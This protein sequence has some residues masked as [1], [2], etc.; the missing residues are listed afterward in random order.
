MTKHS[1]S[2]MERISKRT[3][4]N[5]IKK[6]WRRLTLIGLAILASL[7]TEPTLA[8]VSSR[9]SE[10]NMK[11]V[12]IE[13]L[14]EEKAL[15]L[16]EISSFLSSSNPD[17]ANFSAWWLSQR[18]PDS[19]SLVLRK[20]RNTGM[21]FVGFLEG[22]HRILVPDWWIEM[23]IQIR[24]IRRNDRDFPNE[25]DPP[26]NAGP[27][28]FSDSEILPDEL[29]DFNTVFANGTVEEVRKDN[30]N[31]GIKIMLKNGT[32]RFKPAEKWTIAETECI[33]RR[34]PS[35]KN[36]DKDLS[37]GIAIQSENVVVATTSEQPFPAVI[38]CFEW[39]KSGESSS[40]WRVIVPDYVVGD[41]H[42]EVVTYGYS[43][44]QVEVEITDGKVVIFAGDSSKTRFIMFNLNTGELICGFDILYSG[45]MLCTPKDLKYK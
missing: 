40:K 27:L 1:R 17:D 41:P 36:D 4:F 12:S 30:P 31:D 9:L 28:R 19:D 26:S 33:F 29:H 35:R 37:I 25:F 20:H 34:D 44:S 11:Q 5:L 10:L 32:L 38:E 13:K 23:I 15:I 2:R 3:V 42:K 7:G 16:H 6:F 45:Q 14:E 21:G 22:R 39:K 8:Q 43:H 18:H 24:E